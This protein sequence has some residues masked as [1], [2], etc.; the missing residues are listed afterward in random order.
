M[1]KNYDEFLELLKNYLPSN[2]FNTRIEFEDTELVWEMPSPEDDDATH[3]ICG[4]DP[5]GKLAWWEAGN[6]PAG[7]E[8]YK[9]IVT[10]EDFEQAIKDWD[11]DIQKWNE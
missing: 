8:Y 9:D 1:S 3:F 11:N 2:S 7:G 5:I 4:Y 6:F 10:V